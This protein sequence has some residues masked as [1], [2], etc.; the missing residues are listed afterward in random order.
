M[1]ARDPQGAWPAS[2][3]PAPRRRRRARRT[4]RRR[5]AG[6]WRRLGCAWSRLI[7]SGSLAGCSLGL[8]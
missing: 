7:R 8:G 6:I 3:D 1:P 4:G 2:A 5:G